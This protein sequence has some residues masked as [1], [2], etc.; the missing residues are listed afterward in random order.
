M[1]TIEESLRVIQKLLVPG[2]CAFPRPAAGL[3]LDQ[4]WHQLPDAPFLALV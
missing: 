2:S 3:A 4:S 1:I